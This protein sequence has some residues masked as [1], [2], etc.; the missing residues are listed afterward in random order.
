MSEAT[1]ESDVR[2]ALRPRQYYL[3]NLR[4]ALVSLVVLHHVA[5]T[6]GA[7]GPNSLFYFVEFPPSGLSPGLLVF[8]MVNQAW[9]MG[10]FFLI[11]GYF[12]PGSFD[13]RGPGQFLWGRTLRLGVPTLIY[14]VLLNPLAWF[15]GFYLPEHLGPLTWDTYR[16]LDYVRM[17]PMWFVV[18][19]LSFSFGYVAW[20]TFSGQTSPADLGAEKLGY[21]AIA[22]FVLGLAGVS[23]LMRLWVPIGADIW[24][25]SSL[26]YLPQYLS[27]FV[28]GTIAQR[29]DWLNRLPLSQ[30]LV[31]LGTA[32]LASVVL[33]PL[34]FSGE[35]FS[36]ELTEKVLVA[37]GGGH[38]R[39]LVYAMW[40]SIMAVGLTIGVIVLYR[41]APSTQGKFGAYL[42]THS[43]TVYVIHLPIVVLIA[44]AMRNVELDH[45]LKFGL[46]GVIALVACWASACAVRKI[47]GASEL[48]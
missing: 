4:I 36:M 15:G 18:L 19:L 43:Y 42:A 5:M 34:A 22:L 17:G 8:G 30:G 6:Y 32:T 24:G 45:L 3:D 14:M 40:D 9:F 33:F 29:R 35:W 23:Y 1:T 48:L 28:L 37:L 27:F 20:R 13:R 10:A 21:G 39:S 47:P 41:A 25:F 46:A 38:W 31:G 16:Y 7:A 12:T 2:R 26:A 11:A 44:V